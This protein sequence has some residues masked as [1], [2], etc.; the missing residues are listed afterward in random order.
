M[1]R[2]NSSGVGGIP[3]AINPAPITRNPNTN[4]IIVITINAA[5]NLALI[6]QSRCI[7]CDNMRHNVPLFCSEF[8]ASNP[9]AMPSN[10][11]KKLMNKTKEGNVPSD[12]VN[13]FRKKKVSSTPP[14]LIASRILV[15]DV[16]K[17]PIQVSVIMA[18]KIIKRQLRT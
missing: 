5:T 3:I 4:S 10:G 17:A 15:S 9:K 11:P 8:M 13:N 16:Y 7:G 18:S 14:D 1:I 2:A 12:T 6:M